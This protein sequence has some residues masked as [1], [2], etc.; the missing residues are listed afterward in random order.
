MKGS[1]DLPACQGHLGP[2]GRWASKAPKGLMAPLGLQDSQG[3][4]DVKGP[5]ESQD[6]LHHQE[7]QGLPGSRDTPGKR[8]RQVILASQALQAAP[9]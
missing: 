7:T 5:Q 6:L 2:R 4:Q 8:V 3:L 9:V 1:K